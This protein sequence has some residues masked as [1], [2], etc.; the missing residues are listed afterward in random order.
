MIDLNKILIITPTY[1]EAENI[2]ELES[3][4][5]D[6]YPNIHHLYIDDHSQDETASKI[7]KWI[8]RFPDHIHIMERS[9]KLGLGTAYLSGFDWGLEKNFDYIVQMDAD[10]SHNPLY[11]N[12]M[13]RHLEGNDIVIG[14]RYITGGGT[15]NWGIA[16]RLISKSGCIYAQLV[17]GLSVK[18]LTGGFNIWN[19]K[20]L[21]AIS[22]KSVKSEGYV[23]Q[24]ELKYRSYL[25]GFK[26][27]EYP[28]IFSDRTLGVSKMSSGI[29]FEAIRKVLL[30]RLTNIFNRP[31]K[32]SLNNS[33]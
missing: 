16:R 26:I 17:L 8:G 21:K 25:K 5:R 12:E 1:N 13:F 32:I 27:R 31:K 4:I 30:L 23:F 28:I 22:L 18:D 14:S 19:T 2:D 9:G 6:L 7:H 29:V 24:I 3:T 20:V 15:R 33:H 11:L 10:L